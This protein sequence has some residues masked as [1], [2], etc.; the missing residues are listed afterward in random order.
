MRFCTS[1]SLRRVADVL[2]PS[3]SKSSATAAA[4]SGRAFGSLASK[5]NTKSSIGFV[6][7][8][9]GATVLGAA[10]LRV[11]CAN[12]I[13]SAE[14]SPKI[15]FPLKSSYNRAPSEYTSLRRSAT[16]P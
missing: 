11:A 13:S 15:G 10:G 1:S 12:A 3:R 4:L 14:A 6:I 16:K 5:L 9:R 7:Q 2:R 8:L